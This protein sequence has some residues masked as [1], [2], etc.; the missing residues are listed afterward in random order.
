MTWL[1][2]SGT[3]SLTDNGDVTVSDTITGGALFSAAT[4]RCC[5][6]AR[7]GDSQALVPINVRPG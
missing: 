1:P 7:A 3:G 2:L 5:V 6:T 4:K